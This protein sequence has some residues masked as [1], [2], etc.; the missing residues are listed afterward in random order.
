MWHGFDMYGL[1]CVF[2][3]IQSFIKPE[4]RYAYTSMSTVCSSALLGGLVD[5]DVL[6]DQVAGIKTLRICVCLCILEETEEKFGGFDWPSSSGNTKLLACDILSK[7]PK[8]PSSSDRSYRTLSCTSSSSSVSPHGNGLLMLLHVLQK[9]N[10][11]LQLPA[12]DSL[13]TICQIALRRTFG[14]TNAVSLVFLK[15]TRRY[16]PRAR[17]DF[18]EDTSVAAYRTFRKVQVSNV[19]KATI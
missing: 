9:L 14:G 3:S 8:Y 11:T 7:L 1:I 18:A 13:P 6:D 17:A 4:C 16:A 15:L 5:L 19:K 2:I 10:C 12:I